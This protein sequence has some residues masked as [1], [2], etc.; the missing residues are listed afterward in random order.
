[1]IELQKVTKNYCLAG[2]KGVRALSEVS[3]KLPEKGMVFV[4]GRSG[5]GKSTLLNIVGGLDG[6][7]E[8]DILVGGKS[9]RE[10]KDK[11]YNNYRNNKIGFVFQEYNLLDDLTAADNLA[12][13]LELKGEKGNKELIE[14]ALGEVGLSG[15][16]DRKPGTMSGGQR[17]RLA[18]ARAIVKNPDVVLADE[19]TGALDSE[20][21]EM[22]LLQLKLLSRD[23]LVLVVTHDKEYAEK[24]G[25]R[26]ITLKDGRVLSDTAFSKEEDA[27][28][29]T[30]ADAATSGNSKGNR[31]SRLPL[32]RS[33]QMGLS[34]MR[35][36]PGRM[37]LSVLLLTISLFL[38]AISDTLYAYDKPKILYNS[39]VDLNVANTRVSKEKRTYTD[40]S[41]NTEYFHMNEDDGKYFSSNAKYKA[42]P[43][44]DLNL[45]TRASWGKFDN[46]S[47]YINRQTPK[48][49]AFLSAEDVKKAG[50][51]LIGEMPTNANELAM[52]YYLYDAY[53]ARGYVADGATDAISITAPTDLIGKQIK[54]SVGRYM[55]ESIFTITGIV[56][57]GMD[58]QEYDDVGNF[59]GLVDESIHSMMFVCEKFLE[60]YYPTEK[61]SYVNWAD[62]RI[63]GYIANAPFGLSYPTS[64]GEM[65]SQAAHVDFSNFST[66]SDF[67]GTDNVYWKN[68]EVKTTLAKNE[69]IISLSAYEEWNIFS[70]LR[71]AY[72][73]IIAAEDTADAVTAVL[74][75]PEL[76]KLYI[77]YESPEK[78][79]T[80][81]AIT[82]YNIVGILIDE[83]DGLL[84][85]SDSFDSTFTAQ[86]AVQN[87]Y[88]AFYIFT[89]DSSGNLKK[90]A[91]MS[92]TNVGGYYY[93]VNNEITHEIIIMDD[94]YKVFTQIFIVSSIALLIVSALVLFNYISATI[95]YKK[96]DIGVLRAMGARKFDVFLIFFFEGLFTA[97]IGAVIA[98]AAA[99]ILTGWANG[100]FKVAFKTFLTLLS[101]G[102]RQIGFVI[103]IAV[104]V[105]LVSS[106]AASYLFASKKP[107]DA[108]RS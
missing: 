21:G 22:V 60:T 93:T 23:R 35:A 100:Y 62:C 38:F 30:E 37:I 92:Y 77:D 53:V 25:D 73:S 54:F 63:G 45:N 104:L 41:T 67:D 85:V 102:F 13:A 81:T 7:D 52:S 108:I 27:D 8:G 15:Y 79:L 75:D 83:H 57:T 97:L 91:Q 43:A 11:D 66:L 12:V 20:T 17:Q 1:M 19:P 29:E 70:K 64:Y 42:H 96:K 71:M 55:K 16:G 80:G 39:M 61:F 94:F 10:F 2:G 33:M 34:G 6:Y 69:V 105:S 107:V 87:P 24:F 32:K 82:A 14:K 40:Y 65:S 95:A 86:A 103:G 49:V 9:T 99:P 26:I 58:M 90:L 68:G 76:N 4:L 31:V 5:S 89:N 56:D 18:I 88:D 47:D 48:G 50:F 106:F 59:N 72:E 101:F 51:T 78:I 36:K 74:L 3:L 44:M 98:L 46:P 28:F 84:I